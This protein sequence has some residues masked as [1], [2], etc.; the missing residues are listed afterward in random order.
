VNNIREKISLVVSI[1]A[2]GFIY[3]GFDTAADAIGVPT[4]IDFGETITVTRG[5]YRYSYEDDIDGES[6]DVGIF[7]MIASIML[8]WRIYHWLLTGKINGEIS[9]ESH[10]TW[11]HWLLGMTAYILITTPIWH[12]N[13]PSFLQ[14]IT[15]L[16]C[17]AGI[18]WLA[19]NMH[20]K[21]ITRIKSSNNE[22]N[23]T[24]NSTG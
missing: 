5:S 17:G 3:F 22:K 9:R 8:A 24:N 12:I 4:Y 10:I 20:A 23:L 14:R 18:A 6:T 2:F 19:S 13:M 16:G 1:I 11:I 15:V 21:A 7:I